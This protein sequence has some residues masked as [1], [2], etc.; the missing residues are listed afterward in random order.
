MEPL[1]EEQK[2]LIEKLE[3]L[4][5]NYG[6]DGPDRKTSEYLNKKQAELQSLWKRIENNDE[7][8][9]HYDAPKDKQPYFTEETFADARKLYTDF[10]VNIQKRLFEL[11]EE[12]ET[13]GQ[14]QRRKAMITL[15][16]ELE[17]LLEMITPNDEITSL[18]NIEVK[19]QTLTAQ[20][21]DYRAAYF[22]VID[23]TATSTAIKYKKT[24]E[25]IYQNF[26]EK[27]GQ[28]QDR[29][30]SHQ[31]GGDTSAPKRGLEL[32]KLKI[33]EFDG[34]I[35]AWNNFHELFTEVIHKN[36]N[37]NNAEKMHYL[38]SVVRG[39]AAR[40][41]AHLQ[42]SGDNYMGA[43]TILVKRYEN[44]RILLGKLLDS[45]MEVPQ[46]YDETCTGLKHMHDT[47][48]ECM[49]GI[50]NLKIDTNNWDAI[51]THILIKKFDKDTRKHYECQLTEP[52]KPQTIKEL[53]KYIEARFMS[54]EAYE[55]RRESNREQQ[56]KQ[57]NGNKNKAN[58]MN[59]ACINC[60]GQHNI[61]KCET[62]A[63]L[64]EQERVNMAREKKWCMNCLRNNHKTSEC[65]SK[66]T[67]A[68]CNKNHNTLLHLESYKRGE[69]KTKMP[70]N[71][72]TAVASTSRQ[73]VQSMVSSSNGDVL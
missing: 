53:L 18:G 47:V 32:P 35:S 34:K 51:I 5:T 43:Y 55:P 20:W 7:L 8:L 61:S 13:K 33:P 23:E 58:T 52:R 16:T 9:Q 67:C 57:N 26:L 69:N 22:L 21:N 40:L 27:A 48:F 17:S 73:N 31:N 46:L 2:E 30:N 24:H 50:A 66:F 42:S 70:A 29:K 59:T 72:N 49:M 44:T 36:V 39:E 56:N 41:I 68:K 28:L 60:N 37:I 64:S 1:L 6:K 15:R 63:K 45:I 4:K 12:T 71:D 10:I 11:N 38:K 19:I 54:L 14:I 62:F 3:K 65:R 25:E